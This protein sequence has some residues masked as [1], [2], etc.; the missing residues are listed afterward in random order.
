M[1]NRIDSTTSL[2]ISMFKNCTASNETIINYSQNKHKMCNKCKLIEEENNF[3][4]FQFDFDCE[5]LQYKFDFE[6]K[7]LGGIQRVIEIT[8]IGFNE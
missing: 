3:S 2:L 8:F 7:P 5:S 4:I 1:C 6:K